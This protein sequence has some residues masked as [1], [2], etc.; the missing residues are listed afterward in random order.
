MSTEHAA[1]FEVVVRE[2]KVD[3]TDVVLFDLADPGGYPLPP[4]EPGAHIDVCSQDKDGKPVVRQYSLCGQAHAPTWTIA[5]LSNFLG[6]G[7]SVNLCQNI[8]AGDRIKVRGPKNHFH[9]HLDDKPVLLVAGGIGIT[10]LLAMAEQLHSHGKQFSL[11]HF[12][13]SKKCMPLLNRLQRSAFKQQTHL[14]FD[15]ENPLPIPEIFKGPTTSAWLYICGPVGFMNAVISAAQEAGIDPSRIRKELFAADTSNSAPSTATSNKAFTVR[16]NSS[17]RLINVPADQTV[18]Q[19]LCNAGVNLIVS[20]EQGHCG[21]CL[22]TV[23]E[24][25][26]DHRDQFMLPEEHALNNAFTPCCSRALSDTLVL[27]L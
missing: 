22:T 11:Y 2:V 6:T 26:P 10:P 13:R 21:S 24:G 23:L 4:W 12:A 20:C 17:G 14:S 16:L 3:A 8:R 9:L 7:A 27:D 25:T 15:D 1:F 5:V 19:A 18:V